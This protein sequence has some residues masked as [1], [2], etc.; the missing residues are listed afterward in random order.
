VQI[1]RGV[2]GERP[3]GAYLKSAPTVLG[4]L[5]GFAVMYGT[6]LLIQ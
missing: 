6:G 5:A 3:L 4:L 2:A 1:A